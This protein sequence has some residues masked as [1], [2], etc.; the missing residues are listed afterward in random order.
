MKGFLPRPGCIAFSF[1]V[2][3]QGSA[4]SGQRSA[5][6]IGEWLTGIEVLILFKSCSHLNSGGHRPKADTRHADS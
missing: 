4:I 6:A 1:V 5:L 3:I 2:S